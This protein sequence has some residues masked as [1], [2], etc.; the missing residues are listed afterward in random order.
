MELLPA[1]LPMEFHSRNKAVQSGDDKETSYVFAIVKWPPC[2]LY[3]TRV[4]LRM[5]SDNSKYG[6]DSD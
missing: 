3:C 4:V 1:H 2:S 6:R 5:L